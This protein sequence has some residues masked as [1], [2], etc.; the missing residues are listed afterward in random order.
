MGEVEEDTMGKSLLESFGSGGGQ[1][2]R[3]SSVASEGE[4]ERI[5]EGKKGEEEER[6]PR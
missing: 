3:S 5:E 4:R 2:K 1:S 6:S